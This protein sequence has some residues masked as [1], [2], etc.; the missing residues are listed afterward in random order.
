MTWIVWRQQRPVFIT[1][2]AGLV[3]AVAA[4]LLLRAVMVADLT[5]GNLLDCVGKGLEACGPAANDFQTT[6]FDRLHLAEA[7]VLA[8][9]VLIGVFVGAPLFAR[10][11]E[12]G[13]HALAFTQSVSRTRW[14]ATKFVVAALPALVVVLV[15]QLVVHSWLDAAGQLGPLSTGPFYFTTFEAQGVSP[16]AYTLFAYTL[17]MFAGA[18]FKRTLV[19]MTLTLGLFVAVRAV[20]TGVREHLITPTRVLSD[21]LD[22]RTVERGPLV[23]ESGFLDAKGAVVADPT[24]MM[25][26][27]GKGDAQGAVDFAACYRENGLAQRYSDVIPVD[28]VTTLHLLEASIFAGLAVLFV[29]GSVW[30][31]RRQV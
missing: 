13:T 18:V 3:V 15:Y 16:V 1:L 8:A 14:M 5:A 31:V 19:A 28:Q 12:Q 11:F 7:T 20:L 23:V 29:L 30:A 25:N 2:V 10:E 27:A 24:P 26:C 21:D 22:A 9:P 17:G 6:W 4:I